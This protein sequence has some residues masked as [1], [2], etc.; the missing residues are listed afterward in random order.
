MGEWR[1]SSTITD[2]G[3]RWECTHWASGWVGPRDGLDA[4]EKKKNLM[5]LPEIE[6][7]PGSCEKSNLLALP[8]IEPR[9]V[10]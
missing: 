8:R 1:Y 6:P 5:T 9:A 7:R 2:L 4:V 3:T 10:A